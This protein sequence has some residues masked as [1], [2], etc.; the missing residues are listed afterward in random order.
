MVVMTKTHL[1]VM[2][3]WMFANPIVRRRKRITGA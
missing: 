1:V 2:L 3:S